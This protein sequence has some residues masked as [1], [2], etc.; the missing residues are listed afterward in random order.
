[1]GL[2]TFDRPDAVI[3]ANAGIPRAHAGDCIDKLER[4][5]QR[6]AGLPASG[7]MEAALESRRRFWLL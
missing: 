4:P 3:L 7:R 5:D 2:D 1:M 6:A